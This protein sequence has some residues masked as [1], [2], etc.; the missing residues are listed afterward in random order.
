MRTSYIAILTLVSVCLTGC[1]ALAIEWKPNGVELRATYMEPTTRA[2]GTPLT[3]LAKTN[4]YYQIEGT[5][6]GKSPDIPATKPAGGGIVETTVFLPIVS[7]QGGYVIFWVTAADESGN[8]SR[9]S[10]KVMRLIDRR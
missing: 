3:D 6:G 10:R 4:V 8:E 9:A 7:G 5:R 2:D 1:V